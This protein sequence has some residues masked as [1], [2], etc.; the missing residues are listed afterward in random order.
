M[1]QGVFGLP[2]IMPVVCLCVGIARN[3]SG[4]PLADGLR[5]RL[6]GEKSPSP[7]LQPQENEK[8][9]NLSVNLTEKRRSIKQ[10]LSCKNKL[11]S[12]L[13]KRNRKQDK[14]IAIPLF[15]HARKRAWNNEETSFSFGENYG[16][17][18]K[19]VQRKA[20]FPSCSAP[21]AERPELQ[22]TAVV[23]I[24]LS[25]SIISKILQQLKE[26]IA[27]RKIVLTSRCRGFFSYLDN[28]IIKKPPAI[29]GQKTGV[30]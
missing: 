12:L 29:A 14:E 26:E 16:R 13:N 22:K 9:K 30:T 15:R 25:C 10:I 23:A 20:G 18:L 27:N 2:F 8:G 17:K 24:L 7:F 19:Y 4:K 11:K 3:A 28:L 1:Y 21:L 5:H 6:V